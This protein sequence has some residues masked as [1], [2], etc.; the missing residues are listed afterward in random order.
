MINNG[1]ERARGVREEH[2]APTA[3]TTDAVKVHRPA[4]RIRREDST[5]AKFE[6]YERRIEQDRSLLSTEYGFGSLEECKEHLRL[7]RASTWTRSSRAFSPSRLK[8]RSGR[9]PSARRSRSRRACTKAADAAD[10]I[11][12]GL[13]AF[14]IPGSVA[15]QPQGR[16]RPR[17][18]RRDAAAR[19]DEMLLLPR[20]T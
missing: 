15:E 1:V 17:Q 11:G 8:T 10:A 16:P 2:R 6:G 4:K 20:R 7:P 12:I 14:C 9:I 19:G 5:M 18:S 13:Q 3:D